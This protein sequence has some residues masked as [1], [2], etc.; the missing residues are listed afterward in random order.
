LKIDFVNRRIFR[1]LN[2]PIS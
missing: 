1:P 2:N